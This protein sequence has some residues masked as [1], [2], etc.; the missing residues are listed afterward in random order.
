MSKNLK[1]KY[2]K[3]E[4]KLYKKI[5]STKF[6]HASDYNKKLYS[7]DFAN[8]QT[9]LNVSDGFENGREAAYSI[10]ITTIAGCELNEE[11]S[12]KNKRSSSLLGMII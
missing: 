6:Y 1:Y 10:D 4:G 3:V 9:K 2:D 5:E 7:L 12:S 11:D 8:K